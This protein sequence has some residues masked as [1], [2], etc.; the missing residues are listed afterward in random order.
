MAKCTAGPLAGVISGK[1]GTVVFSRGRYGNYIR[2]G[3]MPTAVTSSPALDVKGRLAK[4]SKAWAAVDENEQ[5]AWKTWAATHPIT[6]RLGN[7]QVLHGAAAF[8]QLNN[9]ILAAG[10]TQIDLPPIASSPDGVSGLSIASDV[11]TWEAFV[12]WSSGVLAVN[13][14]LAS[15]VAV[16]DSTG[17]AYY[18]N[19]LKLVD[20]SAAAQ[21]THLNIGTEIIVR[22]GR[23]ILGQKLFLETEVWNK[24]TGLK[25]G[26]SIAKC[27]VVA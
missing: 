19:L 3:A 16:C 18:K 23:P 13:C 25:S 11:R 22:F 10:G 21:A 24:V 5:D 1:I 17:R 20:I 7:S 15:W 4:L 9:R 6:D 12:D 27:T 8:M 26:C 2:N 14:C